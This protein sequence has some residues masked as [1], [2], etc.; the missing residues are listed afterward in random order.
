MF[1]NLFLFTC[2]TLIFSL[3]WY[4][5]PTSDTSNEVLADKSQG[6]CFKILYV[7]IETLNQW[8][9]IKDYV[10]NDCPTL[11]QF[12]PEREAVCQ[13]FY[14]F[15]YSFL[16]VRPFEFIRVQYILLKGIAAV[17]N[18]HSIISVVLLISNEGET[19]S[20]DQEQ[21]IGCVQ[22][23]Q[24]AIRSKSVEDSPHRYAL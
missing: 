22:G 13:S 1:L 8:M 9:S 18:V 7:K 6:V 24:G 11:S 23:K 12:I 15:Y 19:A 2:L 21:S 14:R 10:L 16:M 4:C 3:N 5:Q 20:P 17:L